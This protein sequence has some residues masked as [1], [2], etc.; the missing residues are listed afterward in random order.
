MANVR[1]RWHDRIRQRTPLAGQQAHRPVRRTTLAT[2]VRAC[3]V[4]S[5]K[6]VNNLDRGRAHLAEALRQLLAGHAQ[7]LSGRDAAAASGQRGGWANNHPE[8]LEA[9][10][11]VGSRALAC[12]SSAELDLAL[13]I[14]D[15][16]LTERVHS[17]AGW[18]LRART[19]EALGDDAEAVEAHERYVAGRAA[20]NRGI[21]IHVAG[22]RESADRLTG[23]LRL[24]QDECPGSAAYLDRPPTDLW[25]EGLALRDE[26]DWEQAES[27]MVAALV[28]MADRNR[29]S[30]QV[31]E[32]L[33]E[34][35]DL[36]AE[37]RDGRLAGS[38]TV[39]GLYADYRRLRRHGPVPDPTL[40]GTEVISL[41]DFRNLIADK[42]ICLVA[43]SQRVGASSMGA[44]IDSYGLVV[45]FNSYRI[46][47]QATGKRTDVH[48]T[49]HKH[50]FNWHKK[51]QIRLVFGGMDGQWR[52]SI[53]H[54]LVPGAQHYLNDDSLRWPVRNIGGISNSEWS[55]IP[56]SGF[57]MAWLLD[58]LDVNP[59]ID[60]IGFDFYTSGAY[61]LRRAMTLPITSVHDS[62]REREWV[63]ARARKVTEMRIALR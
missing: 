4:H 28:T 7:A 37:A 22:L 23:I 42:S 27:R 60:L 49:I 24:L 32:T 62:V 34:F 10:L 53:R 50:D 25:A 41:A 63:M 36:Y 21:T 46:E 33:D 48:A 54:F 57:Q 55:S 3:A 26:G 35:F 31:A 59:R 29:P 5:G 39:L 16:V 11:R 43:N 15:A 13:L 12:R 44:Q 38:R 19:L 45:R 8:L 56:T 17:R 2:A 14:S 9:L 52:Q 58:Y 1:T 40:G 18:R 47:P 61:R 20:G 51:V 6:L 30:T